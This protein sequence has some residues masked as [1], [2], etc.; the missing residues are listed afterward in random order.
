M[1][2]ASESTAGRFRYGRYQGSLLDLA[3]MSFVEN[4]P[5]RSAQSAKAG[6]A[7]RPRVLNAPADSDLIGRHSAKKLIDRYGEGNID[8]DEISLKGSSDRYITLRDVSAG[9][10]AL[11]VMEKVIFGDKA[12]GD[13]PNVSAAPEPK[14]E[15]QVRASARPAMPTALIGAPKT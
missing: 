9:R 8:L 15:D 2:I 11:N 13:A 14:R 5:P 1:I 7:Q 4:P 3:Q 12:K 10:E 6:S